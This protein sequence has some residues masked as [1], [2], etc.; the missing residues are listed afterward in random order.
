[1]PKNRGVRSGLECGKLRIWEEHSAWHLVLK[2]EEENPEQ[3]GESQGKSVR[4]LTHS[5]VIISSRGGLELVPIG[6]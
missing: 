6:L 3:D 2:N 4:M 1:L 5:R